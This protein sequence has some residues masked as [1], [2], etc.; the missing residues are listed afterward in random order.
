[1]ALDPVGANHDAI[2]GGGGV[3][4]A[5]HVAHAAAAVLP[6]RFGA[7]DAHAVGALEDAA[8]AVQDRADDP[9]ELLDLQRVHPIR[10][11]DR[12]VVLHVLPS[13]TVVDPALGA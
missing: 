13:L 6:D 11:R 7:Q 1:L 4:G 5:H 2:G 12:L 9:S 8:V 3:A 10:R